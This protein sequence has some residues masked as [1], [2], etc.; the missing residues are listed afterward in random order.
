M[1][2]V[3]ILLAH[4]GRSSKFRVIRDAVKTIQPQVFKEQLLDTSDIMGQ[5][6]MAPRT[7]K[8]MANQFFEHLENYFNYPGK[9]H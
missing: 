9:I 1:F 5:K 6:K 2:F 3:C 7:K 4:F 8:A